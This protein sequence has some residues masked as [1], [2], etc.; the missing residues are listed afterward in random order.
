MPSK[1]ELAATGH[2]TLGHHAL[3]AY[4]VDAPDLQLFRRSQFILRN[5]PFL[6]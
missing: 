3:A 6:N 4:T 5:Y 2:K 1:M